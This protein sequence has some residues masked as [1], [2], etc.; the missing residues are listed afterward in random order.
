MSTIFKTRISQ[1]EVQTPVV[2]TSSIATEELNANHLH[3]ETIESPEVWAETLNANKVLAA[4]SLNFETVTDNLTVHNDV[5]ARG[6]V[7]VSSGNVLVAKGG[8][9]SF[10]DDGEVVD[11]NGASGFPVLSGIPYV[12]NN[13]TIYNLGEITED[14]D[15]SAIH[16]SGNDKMVQTCEIWFS[17][18]DEAHDIYWPENMLWLDSTD[19]NAPAIVV[20]TE[21]RVAIRKEEN[22]SMVASIA[23]AVGEGRE[24]VSGNMMEGVA[25]LDAD[26]TFSAGNTF[27]GAVDMS[28]ASVTP[29]EGWNVADLTPEA[30]QQVVPMAWSQNAKQCKIWD[31]T[32]D[33]NAVFGG[34]AQAQLQ[35]VTAIGHGTFGYQH[36][37][38]LGSG[39]NAKNNYT[40][41][42]GP[43]AQASGYAS[44]SIGRNAKASAQSSVTLGSAFEDT[45]GSYT[46]T[47]EG[48]GSITIGAGANTLNNG[49][50]E[51]SN[52]VTIGCKAENKGADSV[53]I[54]ASAKNHTKNNVLIGAGVTSGI[55]GDEQLVAI[56]KSAGAENYGVAIGASAGGGIQG[57][58]IGH[59]ARS[60]FMGVS[61][62]KGAY[63][64]QGASAI[65]YNSKASALK[66]IALGWNATVSDIGATAI[67]STAGDGTVTQLYFSGAN[68]PLANT[69]ENGE[70][71]MG[72]VTKDSAGNVL[73]AGTNKLSALFPN[74]SGFQ[75]MTMSLDDEWEAPKVFHPSDLDMPQ[76][77][78]TE[79]E[80]YQP[81]PVY[82]IVEPEIEE[83]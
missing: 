75:P 66:A 76:E 40:V 17:I 67:R 83:I 38:A 22:G 11:E 50:V 13:S 43:N 64:E 62:G 42:V 25:R 16:F 60:E 57:V 48:T 1:Q 7:L 6:D 65:G 56:G 68:T 8:A 33:G 80:E 81:L 24:I 44:I 10:V 30:I 29:P 55:H 74:N 26:N 45:S 21:Y 37:V 34:N 19:G 2:Y 23:Y 15:L 54:G 63:A 9:V 12:L 70:A 58:T 52:S 51:S 53:V 18:G 3:G 20:R 61:C 82:P 72:Y 39:A 46:C 4:N 28:G 41:S 31:L 47:T 71:M 59:S 79:P 27:T 69:Y 35:H 5:D 49:D 32:R 73:A 77:E 78:P 36:C 14:V